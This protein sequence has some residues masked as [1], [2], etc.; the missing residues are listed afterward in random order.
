MAQFCRLGRGS[1]LAAL[2]GTPVVA[3]TH[4]RM[5]FG[6]YD[7]AMLTGY[8]ENRLTMGAIARNLAMSRSDE[9]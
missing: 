6:L 1:K 3:L 5:V 8:T 2:C 4:S 7:F 9:E